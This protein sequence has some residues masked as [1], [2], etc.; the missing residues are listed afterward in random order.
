MLKL[1]ISP[2]HWKL[3]RQVCVCRCSRA[4]ACRQG[5]SWA[6]MTTPCLMARALLTPQT[7]HYFRA[8]PWAGITPMW[9]MPAHPTMEWDLRSES[10]S[11]CHFGSLG[12]STTFSRI[13]DLSY[14]SS[15]PY[16]STLQRSCSSPEH[17]SLMHLYF[18]SQPTHAIVHIANDLMAAE[19][20]LPVLY[21]VMLLWRM[22]CF[23]LADG[24]QLR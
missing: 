15:S 7:D 14:S 24:T 2:Q 5:N 21:N 17:E 11:L 23:V 6:L 22:L 10:L 18:A 9:G 8:A 1:F 20:R 16:T 4:S 3:T 13:H 19:P 12:Q